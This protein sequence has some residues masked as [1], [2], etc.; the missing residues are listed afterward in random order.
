MTMKRS[1][2]HL[3]I[4]GAAAAAATLI[5]AAPAAAETPVPEP[6]SFTSA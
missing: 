1:V 5:M 4:G 3:T 6:R 2:R